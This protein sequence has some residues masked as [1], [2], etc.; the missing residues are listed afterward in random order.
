MVDRLVPVGGEGSGWLAGLPVE[1]D[2]GAEGEDAC[3]DAAGEAGG[4]AGEVVFE[5][6]LVFEV[7]H[8]RFDALADPADRGSGSVVLVVAAGTLQ[9][10]AERGDGGLEV[11]SGEAF[12]RLRVGRG[13]VG[14]RVV[15][16][17]LRARE[18]LPRRGRNRARTRRCGTIR[19]VA[20]PS[21]GGSAPASSH[22]HTRAQVLRCVSSARFVRTAAAWCRSG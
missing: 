18:C 15:A 12:G 4:G 13:S 19:P 11:C 14:G 5:P 7:L 8:D 21:S 3:G 17:S 9:Q 10:S 20:C 22:T 1:V 2:G 6:E 16:A